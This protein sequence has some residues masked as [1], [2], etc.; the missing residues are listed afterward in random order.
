MNKQRPIR[1]CH[2]S[3]SFYETDN[4]VIRYA[5]SLAARGDHVDVFALRQRGQPL[6][7]VR[8]G[9]NIHRIQR[10]NV[11]EKLAATYLLKTFLFL[12]KCF[13]L[14]C[15]KSVRRPY[16]I[17]HVHNIPDF[18]VFA[19]LA[20]KLRGAAVILDIHDI[21][22]ELYAGKFGTRDK[23][24]IYRTLKLTEYLS[25]SFANHVI[26]SNHLWQ[27]KLIDRSV[28]A[29]KCTSILNYPNLELF[30]PRLDAR[31][32][33]G[34]FVFLYPG[35]LNHHQGLDIAVEAFG[36]AADAM[37]GAEFHIYGEGPARNALE[38]QIEILGL[39]G[40]V[41][42]S[43]RVPLHDVPKLMW[44][45]DAGVVPKRGGGFGDEAF[46]TKIL[47]FMACGVPVILSKTK[48]DAH[49]FSDDLVRFVRPG[50]PAD[51]ASAMLDLFHRSLEDR[52]TLATAAMQFARA[53]S[54]QC[55]EGDYMTI[56]SALTDEAHQTRKQVA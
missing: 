53:N 34:R 49:Y 44:S 21:V 24:L 51:L 20:P 40:R 45:A 35:T 46:S 2:V 54:W 42:I 30:T 28:P 22:P 36:K 48:I 19:A 23:S 3:Y 12:I 15:V 43:D 10:R 9:V 8:S 14:L 47:E 18:L 56:V 55:H 37:P 50:E 4:R 25:C 16:D 32:A 1:A 26:V 29:N 11:T 13:C 39:T 27:A 38:R 6:R 7:S 31:T 41:T 17:V 52:S 5:E 33:D